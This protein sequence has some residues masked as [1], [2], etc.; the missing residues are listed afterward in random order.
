MKLNSNFIQGDLMFRYT[1]LFIFLFEVYLL[2]TLISHAGFLITL[3]LYILTGYLG[4]F[5][6]KALSSNPES[7]SASN[8]LA[9]IGAFFL[10]L[11][12][13]TLKLIG[14]I[15]LLPG[16]RSILLFLFS[17]YILSKISTVQSH[18][19]YQRYAYSNSSSSQPNASYL[20]TDQNDETVID[21]KSKRLP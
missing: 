2:V 21:V 15:L 6:L 5:I 20:R 17:Q 9:G 1:V 13:A 7:H 10:L 14:L 8:A 16:V 18:Q 11:P 4:Q 3:I 19:W 12:I